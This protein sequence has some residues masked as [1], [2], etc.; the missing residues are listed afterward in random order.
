MIKKFLRFIVLLGILFFKSTLFI[1]SQNVPSID[2]ANYKASFGIRFTGFIKSDYWYDSRQVFT[3]REDL[4][5]F[6]PLNAK[7]DM[8]SKDINAK[9]CYNYSAMTSRLT[10]V[11]KS[12]GG[13]GAKKTGGI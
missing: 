5:L 8:D 6:Y 2:T 4:F 1:F 9:P 11:I 7:P 3:T 13:L 12:P 10:G